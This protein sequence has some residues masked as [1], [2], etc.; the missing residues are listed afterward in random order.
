[1]KKMPRTL[2]LS[3]FLCLIGLVSGLL[4]GGL[5][6]ITAPIIEENKMKEIA[7]SFEEL[8]VTDLSEVENK[9]D[10][11]VNAYAAK[12]NG[13]EVYVVTAT[14]TNQFTEVQVIAVIE[15]TTGKVLNAKVTGNPSMATHMSDAEFTND[16]LGIIGAVNSDAI[17]INAQ[18]SK[19][20]NSVKNCLDKVYAQFDALGGASVVT[21]TA[22]ATAVE[23]DLAAVQ[24]GVYNQFN[25]K[26][27]LTSANYTDETINVVV[28]IEN[29]VVTYVSS[30]Q[31]LTEEENTAVVEAIVKNINKMPSVYITSVD[32]E[33]K[34]YVVDTLLSFGGVFTLT[35][36]L[37]DDNTIATFTATSTNS[38]PSFT[39]H[40]NDYDTELNASIEGA[41]GQVI[42]GDAFASV[43]GATVSSNTFKA[44]LDLIAKL[45]NGGAN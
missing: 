25:A 34:T 14:D 44:G 13:V 35:V 45:V 18:A 38:N 28:T 39:S 32:A 43:S 5:N 27:K 36:T 4:L 16:K 42:G 15:K 9:I 7:K 21:I 3:L 31:E 24:T 2:Y 23:Q 41:A 17:I 37:N 26:V 40:Y 1:M 22:K 30:A 12:F 20:T 33:T 10:S 8:G 11:V 19:T 6:S 29:K